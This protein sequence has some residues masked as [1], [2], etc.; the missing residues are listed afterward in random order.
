MGFL[1]L[2]ETCICLYVCL[3]GWAGSCFFVQVTILYLKGPSLW[4]SV[5][6]FPNGVGVQYEG[7][8]DMKSFTFVQ[9]PFFLINFPG[10]GVP[11]LVNGIFHPDESYFKG[12]RFFIISLQK[13]KMET[14]VNYQNMES[15][16][17]WSLYGIPACATNTILPTIWFYVYNGMLQVQ[18]QH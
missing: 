8:L 15:H 10:W 4:F 7:I 9:L 2:S 17:K 5:D 1:S 6:I 3:G 12:C 16:F 13:N 14:G 18:L 11:L